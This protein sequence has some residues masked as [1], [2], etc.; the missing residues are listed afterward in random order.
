MRTLHRFNKVF[1][2]ALSD[3]VSA[4]VTTIPAQRK[5]AASGE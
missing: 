4:K 5:N 2:P 1:K 3:A